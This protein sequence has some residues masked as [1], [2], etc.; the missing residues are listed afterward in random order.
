MK[1]TILIR[2][3]KHWMFPAAEFEA[4]TH[5]LFDG[6][7]RYGRTEEE[8]VA[9]LVAYIKENLEEWKQVEVDV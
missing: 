6:M 5:D 2:R 7:R 3:N 8:A 1:V 9:R 4:V